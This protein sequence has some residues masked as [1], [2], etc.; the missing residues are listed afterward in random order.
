MSSRCLT[1]LSGLVSKFM[2]DTSSISVRPVKLGVVTGVE[3]EERERGEICSVSVEGE[4]TGVEGETTG[5][6]GEVTGVVG[7]VTGSV[8]VGSKVMVVLDTSGLDSVN[9]W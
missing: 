5:V 4:A 9:S 8:S 2:S 6:E 7:E 3:G 1:Q